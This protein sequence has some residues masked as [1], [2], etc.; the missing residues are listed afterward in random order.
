[1]TRTDYEKPA[2]SYFGSQ[3]LQ[4]LDLLLNTEETREGAV[5]ALQRLREG[6]T[7]EDDRPYLHALGFEDDPHSEGLR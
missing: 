1:M 7:T 2:D 6:N 3:T 4:N 5:V